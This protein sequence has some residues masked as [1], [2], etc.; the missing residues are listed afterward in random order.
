MSNYSKDHKLAKLIMALIVC[1]LLYIDGSLTLLQWS[2]V[3][4]WVFGVNPIAY[5]IESVL[6]HPHKHD[7]V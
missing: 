6:K 1:G 2:A 3:L 5:L 7:K 4:I